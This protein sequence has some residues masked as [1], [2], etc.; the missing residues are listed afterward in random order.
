MTSFEVK[1]EN[2]VACV[3]FVLL[4]IFSFLSAAK[5]IS[6]LLNIVNAQNFVS[7]EV[8]LSI[9]VVKKDK[10]FFVKLESFRRTNLSSPQPLIS[11][12]RRQR[13]K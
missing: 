7:F 13:P 12:R 1:N 4:F 10:V 2:K 6:V 11:A 3:F 8:S 9:F 5:F